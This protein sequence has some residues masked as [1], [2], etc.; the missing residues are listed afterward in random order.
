MIAEE[1][2]SHVA[3]GV[4]WFQRVCLALGMEDS[5]VFRQW[6]SALCPSLLKVQ[7]CQ[8]LNGSRGWKSRSGVIVLGSEARG[9]SIQT[10]CMQH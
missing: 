8:C 6:L 3:V 9:R 2:K 5:W 4:I 10:V 1:E 7:S